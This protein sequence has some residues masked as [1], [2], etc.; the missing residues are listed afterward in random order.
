MPHP[1]A[2]DP[3]SGAGNCQCGHAERSRAHPHEYR[4]AMGSERCVC[5]STAGDP[6]HT[7]AATARPC[8]HCTPED[9]VIRARGGPA[10]V[11]VQG[12]A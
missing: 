1:Y 9:A 8:D 3:H 7:N 10:P 2:A 6:V 11:R 5:A 4:Q 12:Y